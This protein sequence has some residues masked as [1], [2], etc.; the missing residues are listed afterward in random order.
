VRNSASIRSAHPAASTHAS[1]RQ[2]DIMASKSGEL[3]ENIVLESAEGKAEKHLAKDSA[4]Q[5]PALSDSPAGH[6][7]ANET[8]RNCVGVRLAHPAARAPLRQKDASGNSDERSGGITR[9]HVEDIV[10]RPVEDIVQHSVEDIAE[11]HLAKDS[12]A[13]IPA[14]LD[15][16]ALHDID[17]TVR[18]SV[19]VCL[20]HSA[21]H[22][23]TRQK[24]L[25]QVVLGANP[26]GRTTV[27]QQTTAQKLKNSLTTS[28]RPFR[29]P[30]PSCYALGPFLLL[31]SLL[32][33]P[34]RTEHVENTTTLLVNPALNTSHNHPAARE[35]WTQESSGVLCQTLQVGANNKLRAGETYV[36]V[37]SVR[38]TASGT[39]EVHDGDS[40]NGQA[41]EN[42]QAGSGCSIDFP[43]SMCQGN[44]DRD[45]DCAVNLM[46]VQRD[47]LEQVYG[48]ASGGSGD[49]SGENYCAP[50]PR[51]TSAQVGD[52]SGRFQA[53]YA[54][55][56]SSVSIALRSTS[57]DVW[58]R[59][60]LFK[61]LC[62]PD[63]SFTKDLQTL[64]CE[65]S[66]F[67]LLFFTIEHQTT[68][69][70]VYPHDT[71]IFI[72][73]SLP[74]LLLQILRKAS[75]LHWATRYTITVYESKH[76]D[77]IRMMETCMLELH[78]VTAGLDIPQPKIA[79]ATLFHRVV[80]TVGNPIHP[81]KYEC[82]KI[83]SK[84][85][86]VGSKELIFLPYVLMN[87]SSV[88]AMADSGRSVVLRTRTRMSCG[89][90]RLVI[91]PGTGVTHRQENLVNL[92][93]CLKKLSWFARTRQRLS[94]SWALVINFLEIR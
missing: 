38:S 68:R 82:W 88:L 41:Q 36:L 50:A 94:G 21:A 20:A 10:H 81:K 59:V 76:L 17:E 49:V 60:D 90:G 77:K 93:R 2:K 1:L 84:A 72:F 91:L 3:V 12:A 73:K 70:E 28:P 6:K 30:F 18:N 52:V 26:M 79:T 51:F 32:L 35:G 9:E 86:A 48:C 25:A 27:E 47:G 53:P 67:F 40:C 39:V 16:P 66:L 31:L 42:L 75:V 24:V 45:L 33:R 80:T 54:S 11:K 57:P 62:T 87:L 15:R 61:V 13:Q 69:R 55:A 92:D 63:L 89:H 23:P 7:C 44:C 83:L 37:A 19:G 74:L 34:V 4:A 56:A 43:C 85:R 71:R 78:R 64:V 58:D 46:C 29:G 14:H 5:V 22:A 8:V 65:F